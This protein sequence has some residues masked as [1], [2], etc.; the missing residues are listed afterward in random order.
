M[1]RTALAAIVLASTA[2]LTGL[3]A[4]AQEP[5]SSQSAAAVAEVDVTG[6]G[7]GHGRGMGQFGAFGYARDHGWTWQQITDHFYGGTTL[8]AI[9]EGLHVDA[10][11]KGASGKETFVQVATGSILTNVDHL[12]APLEGRRAVAVVAHA[13]GS[14]T[15]RQS[16]DCVTWDAGATV[17]P[18]PID[19]HSIL[20]TKHDGAD[21][22]VSL[23]G[24][25]TY[26]GELWIGHFSTTGNAG[27][28]TAA[29]Q[30]VM[31]HVWVESYLRSVVP[32][33]SPSSWPFDAL[34]AQAIAA[35]SYVAAGDSRW[36]W[37]STCDDIFCQVYRGVS[38]ETTN[39][40]AA[41]A[42]TGGQVRRAGSAVARTEFSSS[43]GGYTAGG[44]FPAV[45]DEGDDVSANPNHNWTTSVS[46]A[47][48]EA[49][50]D[51]RHGRDLGALQAL[52]VTDRNDLGAD[53]GRVLSIRADFTN[54]SSTVSGNT[55]RSMFGLKSDWFT[56]GA[57]QA[58]PGFSDTAGHTH[59]ENIDK[60][61]AAGI[62]SGFAD[63]TFRPDDHVTRAQMAT[64]ITKGWA[65]PA[66]GSAGFTD[67]DGDTH[68]ANIDAVAAAEITSGC[69]ATTYCPTANITRGQMAVF[70]AEAEGLAPVDTAGENELCDVEG[71]LY[72]GHIRAIVDDGIASGAADG[73]FH[74]D[75]PVTRGQ[76]A[77]FIA[78]ALGL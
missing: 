8:G 54:G 58:D 12:L 72:E 43:T 14:F 52:T 2:V 62:A 13:D 3:P 31:N 24:G 35:R 22:R 21:P 65:L 68:E 37:A 59:E 64:F 78:R 38:N 50:F 6:H 67:T 5:T 46:V 25:A 10:L 11:L 57:I 48:I 23:C 41:V 75:D 28:S 4:G 73:C 76:M 77:T 74:P 51:S 7:W 63:G 53:G 55:F 44:A 1:R 71:H 39:T 56:P 69:T 17:T 42:Q 9:D 60:V 32:A 33:E 20:V 27:G 66:A 16:V 19:G 18:E 34:A 15:V 47:A 70:L 45:P 26:R 49:A 61:A 29:K 40:D 30:H 36:G